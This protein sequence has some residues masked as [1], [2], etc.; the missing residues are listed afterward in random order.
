M[1][2]RALEI[3]EKAYGPNHIEVAADLTNRAL[4]LYRQVGVKYL[5]EGGGS[6]LRKANVSLDS[7]TSMMGRNPSYLNGV[8]CI[9][10]ATVLSSR[11]DYQMVDHQMIEALSPL[12]YICGMKHELRVENLNA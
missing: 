7:S 1:C 9:M 8:A 12:T 11:R 10:K 2:Q 6:S 3:D 5:R 4:M